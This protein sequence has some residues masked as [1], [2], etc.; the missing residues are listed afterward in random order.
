MYRTTEGVLCKRKFAEGPVFHDSACADHFVLF[1]AD[2]RHNN[3][4]RGVRYLILYVPI[5]NCIYYY[6]SSK[7]EL[8]FYLISTVMFIWL[9]LIYYYNLSSF[10][11]QCMIRQRP[12]SD[13]ESLVA[14]TS[15]IMSDRCLDSY[16]ISFQCVDEVFLFIYARGIF[17]KIL[18]CI[19]WLWK[20]FIKA[21][22]CSNNL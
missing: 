7:F 16:L 20:C 8:E 10:L 19:F 13:R 15:P 14:L 9:I 11:L 17:S 3:G 6:Y 22:V 12:L 21:K 2:D 4:L 5:I 18:L 1:P